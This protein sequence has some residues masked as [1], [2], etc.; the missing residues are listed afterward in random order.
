MLPGLVSLSELAARWGISKESVLRYHVTRGGL[1]AIQGGNTSWFKI[2]EV[3]RYEELLKRDWRG[4]I[5]ALA[6]R[7]KRI[8]DVPLAVA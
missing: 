1:R 6:R 8:T 3:A 7:L 5:K 4:K 2:D